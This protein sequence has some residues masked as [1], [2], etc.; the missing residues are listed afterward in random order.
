M[1]GIHSL[2]DAGSGGEGKGRDLVIFIF[3]ISPIIIEKL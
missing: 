2:I 3:E 1:P